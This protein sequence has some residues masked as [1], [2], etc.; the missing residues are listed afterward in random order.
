MKIN[1]RLTK[2]PLG[3][4]LIF[5]IFSTNIIVFSLQPKLPKLPIVH[6]D[7]IHENL[8]K[9]KVISIISIILDKIKTFPT[10][11]LHADFVKSQLSEEQITKA[12]E[13]GLLFETS[14]GKFK[15][16]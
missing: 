12:I 1:K 7:S 6:L 15:K 13:T 8:S 2:F 16:S 14:P 5:M 10:G 4:F 3:I 9:N 11:E